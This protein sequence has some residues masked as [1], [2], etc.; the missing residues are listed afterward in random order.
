M[1]G[2][3]HQQRHRT[4]DSLEYFSHKVLG[5]RSLRVHW[6]WSTRLILD[7]LAGPGAVGQG[8]LDSRQLYNQ[9]PLW[10]MSLAHWL[11]KIIMKI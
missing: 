1:C 9:C 8:T 3:A 6:T 10:I 11:H 5:I 4:S 2:P 7:V